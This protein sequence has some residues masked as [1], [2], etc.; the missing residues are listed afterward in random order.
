ML[1]KLVREIINVCNSSE[2][3]TIWATML[4]VISNRRE[5]META[6]GVKEKL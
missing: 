2:Y 5:E 4:L 3:I 1:Y 6:E